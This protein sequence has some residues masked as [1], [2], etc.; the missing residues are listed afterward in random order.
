MK[1]RLT[2]LQV[3]VLLLAFLKAPQLLA[4]TNWHAITWD[5]D[6]FVGTDNGYTAGLYYTW[7]DTQDGNDPEIGFLASSMRWSLA[8]HAKPIGSVSSKT[9]GQAMITPED[10][11]LE[12]PPETDLPYAGLLYFNDTHISVYPGGF[13]DLIGVTIGITGEYSLAG[14]TQ[15][16]L[17]SIIGSEEPK[18]WDTQ[19]DD[20]IVFRF[21]R[22]RVW[23]GW[24]S[25]SGKQDI[26]ISADAAIGTIS[27]YLG[28][29]IIWRYGQGL[30]RSYA[31]VL[32]S[33]DRSANPVA[34][35]SG[36]HWFAGTGFRYTANTI[37]LDGNTYTDSRKIEDWEHNQVPITI[38]FSYASRNWSFAY[39]L[40]DLN[41]IDNNDSDVVDEYSRYG[42]IT[43]AWRA[44]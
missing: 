19:I 5:N 35:S 25:G 12:D 1:T 7:F 24:T 42:T 18:G 20:E 29:S 32:L 30:S 23:K 22:G 41:V 11:S 39:A 44:E 15:E 13:A 37:F 33:N 43:F 17:H 10:I 28:G 38:G 6:A 3:T 31:T 27:S 16:F 4:E 21:N 26:L 9:I 14:D 34:V 2:A 36:W 40:N 8:E